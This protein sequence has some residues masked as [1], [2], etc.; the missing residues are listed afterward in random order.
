MFLEYCTRH[1]TSTARGRPVAD[2]AVAAPTSTTTLPWVWR[3]SCSANASRTP[4]TVKGNGPA[5]SV[6]IR[7]FE[8]LTS[9]KISA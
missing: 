2:A 8:S 7:S 9:I 3:L 5:G 1:M 6:T 4:S